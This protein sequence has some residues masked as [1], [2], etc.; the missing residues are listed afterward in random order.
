MKAQDLWWHEAQ[1]QG[2]HTVVVCVVSNDVSPSPNKSYHD[3]CSPAETATAIFSFVDGLINPRNTVC[4]TIQRKNDHSAIK[5]IKHLLLSR[6]QYNFIGLVAIINEKY[7]LDAVQYNH[8]S[9]RR[10]YQKKTS[11]L[12][13][14]VLLKFIEQFSG[15]TIVGVSFSLSNHII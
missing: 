4:S 10:V 12:D 9:Y 2:H 1:S 15:A 3:Q 14:F 5:E 6:F 11:V 8:M 7:M 13:D